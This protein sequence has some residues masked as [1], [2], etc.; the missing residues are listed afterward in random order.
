MPAEDGVEK[1]FRACHSVS[2]DAV[3]PAR[4]L[5]R[6]APDI[7]QEVFSWVIFK[8]T[9]Y[10]PPWVVGLFDCGCPEGWNMGRSRRIFGS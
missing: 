6:S 4:V 3:P 9:Y 1:L 8:L 10:R 5:R 2:V 7:N